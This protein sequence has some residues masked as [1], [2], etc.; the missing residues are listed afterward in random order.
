MRKHSKLETLT[1]IAGGGGL[2]SNKTT[3]RNDGPL[4]TL[5]LYLHIV[6]LSYST[7]MHTL[8]TGF[9]NQFSGFLGDQSLSE[10]IV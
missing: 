2:D 5:C 8:I 10:L 4:I 1:A 9:L 3:T 6:R 7:A